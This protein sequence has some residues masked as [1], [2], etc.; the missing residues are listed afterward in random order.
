[1]DA[2][3]IPETPDGPDFV[4]LYYTTES[5]YTTDPVPFAS[6]YEWAVEPANAGSITGMAATGTITWNQSFLGTATISV[7]SV[8]SCG[9][10]EYSQGF[11]VTVD[12][13]TAI[14]EIREEQELAIYPNPNKGS[15]TIEMTGKDYGT[16]D[17]SIYDIS[18]TI[19]Y[20]QEN[21]SGDNGYTGQINM[22]TCPRGM[23]FLKVSYK[24]GVFVEKLLLN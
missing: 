8:N 11:D 19:V 6:S 2:P 1:M 7:K 22:N 21:I 10:S 9:G 13:F 12:N 24:D 5:Q 3:D 15:F 23:Y 18:G 20:R 17:V 4:N 16:I 14:G